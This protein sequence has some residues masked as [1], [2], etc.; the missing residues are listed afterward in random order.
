MIHIVIEAVKEQEYVTMNFFH[1]NCDGGITQARENFK[2][3]SVDESLVE[4][5][6]SRFP[7]ELEH[8]INGMNHKLTMDSYESWKDYGTNTIMIEGGDIVLSTWVP[9]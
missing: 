3:L 1:L 6:I 2:G 7:S 4:R 8:N 5:F 9:F